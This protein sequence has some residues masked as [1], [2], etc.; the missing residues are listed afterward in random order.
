MRDRRLEPAEERLQDSENSSRIC[1]QDLGCGDRCEKARIPANSVVLGMAFG[2]DGT[3]ITTLDHENRLQVREIEGGREIANIKG[4]FPEANRN[5][6]LNKWGAFD[7]K[8]RRV[9]LA[10]TDIEKNEFGRETHEAVLKLWNVDKNEF[11]NVY[12]KKQLGLELAGGSCL[13]SP[14]GTLVVV[15]YSD[16]ES[17]GLT[18]SVTGQR[19]VAILDFSTLAVLRRTVREMESQEYLIAFSPDGKWFV[20]SRPDGS[21]RIWDVATGRI[22]WTIKGPEGMDI[23]RYKERTIAAR[24]VAFLPRG[25]RV[26]SGGIRG[27]NEVDRLTNRIIPDPATGEVL[28]VEPLQIWEAEFDWTP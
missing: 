9:A 3:T 15:T 8:V 10:T 6:G 21:L 1:H 20:S 14:D 26:V 7:A 16:F 25:I 13:L 19:K 11:R 4:N 5:T 18:G 12:L 2:T 22:A 23:P 28:R 27:W 17:D 24:A